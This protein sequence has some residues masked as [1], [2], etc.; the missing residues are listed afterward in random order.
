MAAIGLVQLRYLD[1]DN[2]YRRQLAQWYDEALDGAPGI[3]RVPTRDGIESSR[4]LYQVRVAH[5]DAFMV[6]LNGDQIF[7]GVHYRDNTEYAIFAGARGTCPAARAFSAEVVS[8]PMHLRM[9]RADVARV[10][11]RARHHAA[12]G[13]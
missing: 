6:A 2:A 3:A 10:G 13:A 9:T 11:E 12:R 4:H 5:R 8:L 7:P 1:E